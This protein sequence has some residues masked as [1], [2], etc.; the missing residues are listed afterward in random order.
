MPLF[1]FSDFNLSNC[2]S[3]N[4]VGGGAHDAPKKQLQNQEI[5]DVQG[6]VPYRVRFH[7]LFDKLEFVCCA[8]CYKYR[9]K[10]CAILQLRFWGAY[11]IF[12]GDFIGIV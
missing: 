4:I 11:G 2:L 1:G 6:A 7:Y 9:E 12:N 5:R 3:Y 8:G 10:G